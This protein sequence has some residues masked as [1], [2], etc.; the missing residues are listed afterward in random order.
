M[1]DV[2]GSSKHRHRAS[3]NPEREGEPARTARIEPR[4][5]GADRRTALL[6]TAFAFGTPWAVW[7]GASTVPESFTASLTAAGAIAIA[8][9][10]GRGPILGAAAIL[11]ACLSR[12]EPWPVAAV[13][14]LVALVRARQAPPGSRVGW[15]VAAAVCALGPLLWIAWNAHAHDGPLHFFRRVSSYKRAIGAGATD[16]AAALAAY[17]ILLLRARPEVVVP[18]LCLLPRL[19]DRALR[20]RWAVPLACAAAQLAFL[21]YGNVKDGAPAHHPERALL[22]ALVLLA[23]FVAVLGARAALPLRAAAALVWLAATI[24]GLGDM[25]GRSAAEDRTGALARGAGLRGRPHLVVTPCAFEHFALIAAYG[26]PEAVTILPRAEPPP[27]PEAC[28]L[29]EER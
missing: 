24:R 8:A 19:R 14:G 6:A 27:A 10:G 15:A 26:A 22:G 3:E 5:A 23:L 9:T 29:V 13:L 4:G 2:E 12:Y 25:P 11:A 1:G 18:A 7:L 17:P 20:E 28:P 21:A 16:S